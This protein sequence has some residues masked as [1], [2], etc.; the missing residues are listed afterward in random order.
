MPYCSS[1]AW[2][3]ATVAAGLQFNGQAIVAAVLQTLVAEQGMGLQPGHRL[4]FGGCSAGAR[5]AMFNLDY[6]PAILAAAG[7]KD[8]QVQGLLDSPLWIDVAP[9]ASAPLSLQCQAQAAVGFL[10]ASARLGDGC[11]AA[12]GAES[13]ESWRCLFGEY[14]LPFLTTPYG[15]NAAQYDTFQ[16]EYALGGTEPPKYPD[17]ITYADSFG[18]AMLAVVSALPAAGQAGSA[19]FSSACF[20]HC[21]TLTESFWGIQSEGVSFSQA[22]RWWYFGGCPIEDCPDGEPSQV[23]EHCDEGFEACKGKCTLKRSTKGGKHKR[24]YKSTFV[25]SPGMATP[26]APVQ[27]LACAAGPQPQQLQS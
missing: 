14:R 23:I 9:L 20:H 10:N 12:Y 1:D 11:A 5:G 19:V 27:P 2:V 13:Q 4:L 16:L 26:P 3:G 6:V 25:W 15:L 24:R 22:T 8:I 17:Q 7:A 18:E 21:V